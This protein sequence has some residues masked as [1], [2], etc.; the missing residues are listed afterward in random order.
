MMYM[1]NMADV[2]TSLNDL[3]YA[4]KIIADRR[5]AIINNVFSSK[6]IAYALLSAVYNH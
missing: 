4:H 2:V 1:P 5:S 3:C 6:T